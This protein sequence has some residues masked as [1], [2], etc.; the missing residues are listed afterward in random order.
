ME[1]KSEK[2]PPA[3]S[4]MLVAPSGPDATPTVV[5]VEAKAGESL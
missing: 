5:V 4:I 3:G 1:A 2:I